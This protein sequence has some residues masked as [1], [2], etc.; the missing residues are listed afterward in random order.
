FCS[1]GDSEGLRDL[2]FRCSVPFWEEVRRIGHIPLPPYIEREDGAMDHQRYQTV[3]AKELGSVAAPTA[4]LHFDTELL[5]KLKNK[6]IQLAEIILHVGI[7]T[8]RPVKAER[9]TDHVMH[10]ELATIPA[11]CAAAINLAK[12]EGRRV[13]CVGTTSARSVES[14]WE[15]GE[16][17]SG[18]QWT[19]IF[20][21]PGIKFNVVDAMITNFHLPQSTLLMMISAFA[22]YDLLMRA[23]SEAVDKHY[24]FFSY[25]D[26]M[27]IE[28]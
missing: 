4:G 23:Y 19:D 3:Y 18:S 10:S 11:L 9:I 27:F 12:Q 24:R 2:S 16:V 7:G 22:G 20:I 5:E 15:N 25:G 1:Q 17:H 26:A 28:D 21:Y 14:F 13:I 6:G 8:F